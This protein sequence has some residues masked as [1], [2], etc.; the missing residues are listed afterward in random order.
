MFTGMSFLSLLEV[1]FWILRLVLKISFK[2]KEKKAFEE[3]NAP[4]TKRK[5]DMNTLKRR[6]IRTRKLKQRIECMKTTSTTCT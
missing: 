6:T 3:N 5:V 4:R 1:L 2:S